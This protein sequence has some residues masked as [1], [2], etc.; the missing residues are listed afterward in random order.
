LATIRL[1]W[2]AEPDSC[3]L[4]FTSA[5]YLGMGHASR[6]LPP[7]DRLTL[8]KPAALEGPPGSGAVE[9]DLAVL[10]GCERALLAPSTLH[11]YWDLFGM[12]ASWGVSIFLD[13]GSYPVA[14]WGAERAWAAGTPMRTFRQHDPD[15]LRLLL[16]GTA[17]KRPVVVADG[18]CPACGMAAPVADYLECVRPWNGLVVID[19]TQSLGIFGHSPGPDAPYGK[20]GGGSLQRAC[21]RDG[22]LVIVSSLAKAF[23]APL[24]ALAGSEAIVSAFER[25]SATRVHCSPPSVAAVAAAG[26]ALGVNSRRG[27][28]L[29]LRLAQ[30]VARLRRGLFRRGMVGTMGLFP[31]QALRFPDGIEPGDVHEGLLSRGIQ[32]VLLRGGGGGRISVILTAGHTAVMVDRLVAALEECAKGARCDDNAIAGGRGAVRPELRDGP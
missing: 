12:F 23:G 2:S 11:L 29:R 24:A 20:G 28:A 4:D 3:V 7:F 1:L 9:R 22:R 32:T 21:L 16:R 27:D 31:V 18:F 25:D 15:A 10:T 13:A 5:L 6:S 8:G 19:D 14:R 17:G 30:Q 26:L